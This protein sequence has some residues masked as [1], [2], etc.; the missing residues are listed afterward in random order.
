MYYM[1]TCVCVTTD[2]IYT[3]GSLKVIREK[4]LKIFFKSIPRINFFPIFVSFN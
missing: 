1:H 3:V 4:K 2:L